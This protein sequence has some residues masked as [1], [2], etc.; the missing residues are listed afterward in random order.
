MFRL[1]FKK[2]NLLICVLFYISLGL[3]SGCPSS[4]NDPSLSVQAQNVVSNTIFAAPL[5]GTATKIYQVTLNSN[6]A[7][8]EDYITS[9]SISDISTPFSVT[10]NTCNNI[11]FN[12][13]CDI[14]VV[15]SPTS[16]ADF[17]V[18]QTIDFVTSDDQYNTS[19][20][21]SGV[22]DRVMA[23][24][25]TFT[26]LTLPKTS[27]EIKSPGND[28]NWATAEFDTG[29]QLLF[30]KESYLAGTNYIATGETITTDFNGGKSL[31]GQLVYA[32]IEVNTSPITITANNVPVVMIDDNGF[33]NAGLPTNIDAIIGSEMNNQVALWR[34]F[35]YPYNETLVFNRPELKLHIGALSN[36]DIEANFVYYQLQARTDGCLNYDI[37]ISSPYNQLTCW[38][39]RKIEIS[40]TFTY[41]SQVDTVPYNSLFDTGGGDTHFFID[42]IPSFL[43]D[44]IVDGVYQGTITAN[45]QTVNNGAMTIPTTNT[46]KVTQSSANSVN[47]GFEIFNS[48]E[49]LF[50]YKN[51]VVGI[52]I[53]N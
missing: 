41:N 22:P 16:N 53:E 19:L 39:A 17:D 27:I 26:F 49:V 30:M 11:T 25:Q 43:S 52:G 9:I 38:A 5:S 31:S 20:T 15:Y 12:Q 2:C 35:S 51:G 37:E 24:L 45:L 3:L 1:Y 18:S 14:T 32:D 21:I 23:V 8:L 36:S 40:Y 7:S 47:F 48:K 29:S 6:G 46:V 10:Q 44:A 28:L 33:I 42:P 13:S 34:Y 4:S 50:D